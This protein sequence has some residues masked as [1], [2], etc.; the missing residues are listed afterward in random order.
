VVVSNAGPSNATA[1]EVTDLLPAGYTYV[2]NTVT[3]GAYVSGTGVWT[4]GAVNNGASATLTI[5]ATVLASGSYVNNAQVTAA[6]ETD[7]DSTPGD[8]AGDD[9]ATVTPVPV[10]IIDLSV[11]K[12]V[13]NGTPNVG[14]NVTFTVVVSNAGPSNAT[15]V[16]VT[17]LLP[18][19]YTYVSSTVT[20]G[21]YVSGTGVWTVGA[22]NNGASATLTITATVLAS[23]SYTNN[24]QV[25]AATQADSDST[26]GDNAGDDF[27]TQTPVPVPIIDLS[28]SK[29]VSNGTPNVG[30]NVTFTVV[31]SNAGPSNATGVVVTDLLPTGYTYVS[32]TV[33]QGAYVSGTGVWTVGAV[34]NGTSATLTVTA[35]VLA[36]G[37]YTNNAQVTAAGQTDS[38]STPGDNAGDDF[39]SQAT[40]PTP[41]IDLSVS[42]TV[43]NAAP[44]FGSNVTFT[45]TVSNAGPS[46]ATGVAV[47]DLLPSGYAFVSSSPSQGAYASG[48]GI[49][50]VGAV[51]AGGAATL[52]LTATVNPAGVYNNTAEVTAAAQSDADSTPANGN[53]AEDDYDAQ[54]TVPSAAADLS[55]TQGV[56]NPAPNVG[57]SIIFTLTVSN[58]GPSA[59][60]GVVVA[61]LIPSGYTYVSDDGGGAYNSGSGV[62]TVG[63]IAAGGSSA[64]NITVTVG[65]GG[66]YSN[67][68]EVTAANEADPDSTPGNGVTTEDDYAARAA[69]PNAIISL[70]IAAD[71]LAVR[72]GEFILYTLTITN[73][74]TGALPVINIQDTLPVGVSLVRGTVTLNGAPQADPTPALPARFAAGALLAGETKTLT[75]RA[76]VNAGAVD[77]DLL[78]HAI[79]VDSGTTPLSNEASVTVAMLEDPEFDLGTIIGKVF[80]DKDGN[81][82]Q[83][84]AEAGIGGVMVA[85][86]DGVYSI[87]DANGMYHIAAVRP[88]NRLVKINV[89]TLPPNDGLTLP[90]AQ[91]VTL[92]P[93]LLTKVNFGVK[94]KQTTVF[95]KGDPGTYGIAVAGEQVQQEAEVIGNLDDMTAVVNGVRA[96]LP[97]A[98][99]KMD[100]LSLERNLRILNGKL[101]KP[102]VFNLSY[103]SDRSVREVTFEIFDSQMRRIRGFRGRELRTN[104]IVWDG[105]DSTG[106]LVKGGE[107]YQYQLTIEF[108][109]GSLSKSPLRLFGVNRTSFSTF[110]LTGASFEV[111]SPIL[112]A[113]A[114]AVLNEVAATLK[115]Y[116]NEKIVVRGHTDSSGDPAWNRK[117]SLLRATSV[118]DY[119]VSAGIETERL[120]IEGRG[121]EDPAAP[122]TT[123][124]GRARNR[125]VEIKALLEDTERA[126]VGAAGSADGSRQVIVNGK[127]IPADEDGS[128]RTVVDAVKDRGRVYVGIQT[129]DGGVA[130]ATVNLPTIAILDPTPGSK[131]EIGKREDVIKLMQPAYSKDGPQYPSVDVKVRGRT[132]PGNQVLIDGEAA[133]VASDGSFQTVLP[134]SVGENT[135]GVVA[136]APNGYTSL[137]NLGVDLSGVD[138]NL[139]LITVRKPVPQFT[140][141]LPPSGAVLSSPN[142]LVRGQVPPKS[143][144]K[145]NNWQIPVQA[146]GTLG[147]TVRLPEGPSTISAVV[148]APNGAAVSLGR[149]VTVNSNYIFVVALGDATV[150]K[151]TTEGP[152]PEKYQDDLYVDGRVALYLKGR[153]QGKYLITA[154]LDTGDGRLSEVG[155]RL[156]DRDNRELYRNLDPDSFYPVYGDGSRTVKDTNSQGRFY[157]LFEAPSSSFQWG[158]YNSGLTGNEFS[159]F[160]RSLYGGKGTWHSLQ[161][162]KSGEPMGEAIVFAALPETRSAHDEFRGT[163]GSLYFLRNKPVVPGSEKVRVEVRDKITGVPVANTTRRNYVDYEIDY[164]EGRVIFRTPVSSVGDSST[165]ISDGLLNGNLVF[166]VVDYEYSNPSASSLDENTYG[167]RVKETVGDNVTLGATYVQ[168]QRPGSTYTLQGGDVTIRAAG[169]TKVTMEYSQSE[170][171][172]LA[173]YTSDDGGL[174][175]TP[176]SVP[177]TADPS[178]AY[179]F[180]LATGKGRARFTSYFRHIDAGFSSSFSAGEA[181]IDQQGATLALKVGDSGALHLLL[182]HRDVA[183]LSDTQTGT[184]QFQ[185]TFGK[186]GVAAEARYRL[187]DFEISPD[188]TEGIG[189]IRV[190]FRPKPKID[191]FTRYQ[192]DFVQDIQGG[193][194]ASG[195]K[196]QLT[197][198]LGAQITQ[199]LTARAEVT[200]GEQGDSALVGLTSKVDERTSLYGTYS[201]SPD[202]PGGRTG[203]ATLGAT[204]AVTDRT[205]LYTE[206]QFKRNEREATTTN[207]LGVSTRLSDRLTTGVSFERSRVDGAGVNPDTLRQVAAA[208]VSFVQ[209]RFK[210]FSKAEVRKDEG[211]A[212]DR[213]QW[214]TTN[215]MELKL[216]RDFTL[217]GRFSYG[218]TTDNL[219][220]TDTTI[221]REQGFGVAYRPVMADWL[222]FLARYT[223][224]RN[225]PPSSQTPVVDETTDQVFSF[226]TVVDLHRRLSLTEK[227][228]VRNRSVDQQLFADLK[229]QM[230]LWI[231]RLNYHL[232]DTWDAA[233]EY[234][235]LNMEQAGDNSADGFLF[236]INRLFFQHLRV[237]VGYN[238]TDFTDNEFS[239]NDYSA[240]GVFFRIQGKY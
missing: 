70:A 38:D 196:E 82:V 149:A 146:N 5:T 85:M 203:V 114:G 90:E 148:T 154:G 31:V 210:I 47:T 176:K 107:I 56:S 128:F 16:E 191:I 179:R 108:E 101:D 44:F 72:R 206:E 33:T 3:Q 224:V 238:F 166:V 180:E 12:A 86:E 159:S 139:D 84:Q 74:S 59:A 15:A 1:V 190:D 170:N 212:T 132:D 155:S 46:G 236:E 71:V 41:V 125:R 73:T 205:R 91:T 87:T 121:A 9:F 133:S 153:I 209:P 157:V 66:V 237:G 118:R 189:A 34:N 231:N 199:A 35:T 96:R 75:Y 215:A 63:A 95:W 174:Q 165:L 163:G 23:G 192:N 76:V 6:G 28:V 211:T 239:A 162:R 126:R 88:G 102:A 200:S 79:A 197:L 78:N 172:A 124:A 49:W 183:G 142:L 22:V 193:P 57:S 127:S 111:N 45:L 140:I 221:F 184:L 218:V 208:S 147:G 130:A 235:I 77:G 185:Q 225:L 115:K 177:A 81:G 51:A 52:N 217:L 160:N 60:S 4:V 122:N 151:I 230:R 20:Q 61:D 37:S 40:T 135:F 58:A 169:D 145:V 11:T 164:A 144:V 171:E 187:V 10:P 100:V 219:T 214:L 99:V 104:K 43:N 167:A 234:R 207:V 226:Q 138:K 19:G 54:T 105:K 158:N 24:A 27:A 8:N 182:D 181:E 150:N 65:A 143:T 62:W 109:D 116:P 98:R 36:S 198:G 233:L 195:S 39:A 92:T 161:K 30:T 93:G 173:Q 117:L 32:N 7:A 186:W 137:V 188:T 13:S 97:K 204:T 42:K 103:P 2:S 89:H 64:L 55:L 227:Y 201:M 53:P 48:T 134:L 25:T 113:S 223:E 50:T 110:E 120:V 68:A 106:R 178:Q 129:E 18:A 112:N 168:E 17:D 123:A 21:A 67:V 240:K 14:T 136:V 119:L 83:G 175:F 152:V 141:E 213:G 69:A 131:I 194:S 202:Q 229:S 156:G 232:S 80:D 29:A 220:D 94:R 228:A 222:N 26:P 216:N